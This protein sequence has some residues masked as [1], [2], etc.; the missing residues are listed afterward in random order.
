[1]A[2]VA[3]SNLEVHLSWY[4]FISIIALRP[5]ECLQLPSSHFLTVYLSVSH[6]G[7]VMSSTSFA[8]MFWSCMYHVNFLLG[9]PAYKVVAGRLSIIIP[10]IFSG[11]LFASNSRF[12]VRYIDALFNCV[13]AM[14]VTGLTTT[15]LS[16]LTGWQQT[17][18]VLLMCVGN[19]VCVI[20][21]LIALRSPAMPVSRS[22]Y[23]G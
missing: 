5:L 13:S 16:G 11:I 7:F 12:P 19:P 8:F 6:I 18:L 1:M 10:L 2:F 17:I 3:S 9:A 15:D 21:S 14:T 20:F 23:H 4:G 22:S